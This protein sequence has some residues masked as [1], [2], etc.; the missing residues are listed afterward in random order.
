MT[1]KDSL[2]AERRF[3]PMLH[4]LLWTLRRYWWVAFSGMLL[5]S[6][7][8]F[9]GKRLEGNSRDIFTLIM[10]DSEPVM[11]I[12]AVLFGVFAAFCM[13]RFLWSRR[14]S[15][16]YLSVGTSRAK[17]F[18]LRYVFGFLSVAAGILVPFLITYYSEISKLGDD[19]FGICAHYT[20]VY[21]SSL[22]LIALLAY[23]VTVVIAV[24]CGSFLSAILGI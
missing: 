23:A 21:I 6:L 14:E 2:A 16:L 20:T 18:L 15:V 13:F 3:T 8:T 24:L 4:E 17:Q 9:V 11:R 7:L 1:S 12:V 10:Q 22:L 19:Y 5:F